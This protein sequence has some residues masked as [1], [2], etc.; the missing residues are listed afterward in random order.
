VKPFLT[1][2]PGHVAS[3]PVLAVAAGVERDEARGPV[4]VVRT[5]AHG[6]DAFGAGAPPAIFWPGGAGDGPAVEGSGRARIERWRKKIVLK[7]EMLPGIADGIVSGVTDIIRVNGERPLHDMDPDSTLEERLSAPG[8]VEPLA[9][10]GRTAT[11]VGRKVDHQRV[12]RSSGECLE[13]P[14]CVGPGLVRRGVPLAVTL[15]LVLAGSGCQPVASCRADTDCAPDGVCVSGFCFSRSGTDG[16]RLDAGGDAGRAD[17]SIVDAGDVDAGASDA[18]TADAGELLDAGLPFDAGSCLTCPAGFACDEALRQ[19]TLRVTGLAFV[20]PDANDVFGG[21]RPLRVELEAELETNVPLPTTLTVTA[22]PSDFTLPALQLLPGRAAWAVDVQ[23]PADSGT[24]ELRGTLTFLDAG[25]EAVTSLTVDAQRPVIELLAEPPP[26]RVNDGGFRDSD[27]VPVPGAGAA[28]VWKKDELVELRV[29]STKPVTVGPSDFGLTVT[30]R[31]TCSSCPATRSCYCFTLDLAGVGLDAMRGLV[32]AG[33]GPLADTLGNRSTPASL[34]L[35]V[36][37]F[38]WRRQLL[39]AS[40][41]GLGVLQPPAVDVLGRVYV[42]VGYSNSSEGALWQVTPFGDRRGDVNIETVWAPPLFD[43]PLL[44][45]QGNDNQIRR[46]DVGTADGGFA[47]LGNNICNNERWEGGALVD[48]RL[49]LLGTSGRVFS[50]TTGSSTNCENWGMQPSFPIDYFAPRGVVVGQVLA[51]TSARLFFARPEMRTNTGVL[52]VDYFP[53]AMPRFQGER[54]GPNPQGS[55]SLVAFDDVVAGSSRVAMPRNAVAVSAW[56]TDLSARVDARLSSDAGTTFGPMSVAGTRARPVFVLGDGVGTLRRFAYRPPPSTQ[57]DAGAFDPELPPIAGVD[58]LEGG[59]LGMVAPVLGAGGLAY[60]ISPVTGRF[61]VVNLST[62]TVAWTQQNAFTPGAVSPALDVWR[63]RSL[64]K[65]CGRG[66]GVLYVAARNDAALQAIIVDS[67]GLDATAPWPR[68][69]H[70][71][72]NTGNPETPLTP[73][74][75][76]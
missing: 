65:H 14:V 2:T 15:A 72:A 24:W 25:F 31:G 5:P 70:D 32:D 13:R 39:E 71:N 64:M 42:G 46:Y 11:H 20:R 41:S 73:W 58:A 1:S 48:G 50:G 3:G 60:L 23:A 69:H 49:F 38:R 29:E 45:A 28:P 55:T 17:A 63:D 56:S 9:Q 8:R 18:G 66:L 10:H 21:T 4:N 27:P 76:P 61:T 59:A 43:G 12:A 51:G 26:S 35:P 52:R 7:S 47:P 57:P 16:G 68:F 34:A 62:G 37:R 6:H 40:A 33:V 44:Y 67:P 53:S 30:P 54:A 19:C 36:T 22:T 75:C 74:S